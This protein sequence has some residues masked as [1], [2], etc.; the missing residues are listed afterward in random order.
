MPVPGACEIY[1]L[2]LPSFEAKHPLAFYFADGTGV[3]TLTVPLT[4]M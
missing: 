3:S 4:G 2:G 1:Q